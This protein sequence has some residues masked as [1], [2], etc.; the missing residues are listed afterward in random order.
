MANYSFYLFIY[1]LTYFS[2]PDP[3][4]GRELDS[5]ADFKSGN[6]VH[7]LVMP[8]SV[9]F[10]TK[11]ES[12]HLYENA[13]EEKEDGNEEPEEGPKLDMVSAEGSSGECRYGNRR[14]GD[15][16]DL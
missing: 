13:D 8:K 2:S 11:E 4:E 16:R 3:P 12:Q 1:F 7:H 14:S 15:I 10:D 6:V 5:A 9:S